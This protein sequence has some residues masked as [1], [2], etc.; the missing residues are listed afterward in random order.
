[1]SQ[2]VTIDSE[3]LL[4]TPEE[5]AHLLHVGRTR[6]YEFI[7]SGDLASVKIGRSRRIPT[8]ALQTFI[9]SLTRS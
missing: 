1:M 9:D 3:R 2:D 6:V 8:E 4:L 7:R 5:V